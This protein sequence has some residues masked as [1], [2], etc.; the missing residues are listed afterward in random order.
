MKKPAFQRYLE[1]LLKWNKTYNLTAITDPKEIE[2]KHFEDS[3]APLP[4]LPRPCRLL[5]LG[6]G[7][8]FPGIP[9]KI[10]RPD[11]EVV[12][13]DAQRKR[14]AFCE[15]VIRELKLDHIKVVHGRAEDK[16]LAKDL[17]LFDVVISRATFSLEQFL[18]DASPL[19]KKEGLAIAMKG[20]D[21]KKEKLEMDEWVLEKEHRYLLSQNCGERSLLIFKQKA[22]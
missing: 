21:W 7:A 13:L 8:G 9:L 18:L 19:L 11:L 12:L 16:T 15:A 20:P 3:L 1:L 17:S 22:V 14:V 2:I 4:F 6:S 5:D 10:E